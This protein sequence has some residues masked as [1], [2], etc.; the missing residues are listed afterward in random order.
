MP[1][2]TTYRRWGLSLLCATAVCTTAAMAQ[3]GVSPMPETDAPS[4]PAQPE[5][6]APETAPAPDD[7]PETA[8]A[9]DDAP[10]AESDVHEQDRA[11]QGEAVKVGAFGDI[12]LAADELDITTV[13]RLL[14]MKA[15]RNIITSRNVTGTVSANI[16]NVDFYEALE[17]ILTTN[18]FGYVEK[19]NFIYVYTQEELAQLEQAQRQRKTEIIRLNYINAADASTFVKSLL[20]DGGSIA[21]SGDAGE[22]SLGGGGASSGGS[23]GSAFSGNGGNDYAD[24]DT[25]VIRDYEEKIE[26]IR[27]L[28]DELDTRP[29]QVLIESTILQARLSEANAFGVDFALFADLDVT[30][31]TNPL[32]AVNDLIEGETGGETGGAVTASPGNVASGES[33]MKLGFLGNDAAVF[34]R[35]LDAVTDTTVL[36]TPKIAVLNRQAADLHVG[37]SLGYLST[38]ATE[39]STTQTVEFLDVGTQ[40]TVRPFISDDG[41]VR[42]EL[43][44]HVSDGDTELVGGFVIPNE[45]TQ[46]L[47]TNVIV[48]NGQTVVLGGLFKEDTSIGRRQV[49]GLGSIPIVGNAFKGQDDD[50]RRS[51]VIF[52]IKPTILKDKALGEA[53]QRAADNVE[54]ARVGAREGLLPWSQTKLTSSYVKQA[55]DQIREG[56]EEKALWYTNLA[57]YLDPTMVDALRLKEHLSG[58]DTYVQ[59][60]SIL[61]DAIDTLIESEMDEVL[62]LED[63]EVAPEEGQEPAEPG[64]Q[65]E[66]AEETPAA[67][68]ADQPVDETS[69]EE[70]E[71]ASPDV[72]ANDIADDVTESVEA[73]LI[74][75]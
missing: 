12:Q 23:G 50:V 33:T 41:F 30:D 36:A 66:P 55:H 67:R 25:L 1:K 34:I 74:G 45:T 26:E 49:P 65:A 73:E 69:A 2:H 24:A 14:S 64:T 29:R 47:T 22:I 70:E 8:P 62:P 71:V 9:P 4:A 44:P 56:D 52:L 38:T 61:D 18:G 16:Q 48:R 27:A 20:S 40:L 63:G 54:L 75:G 60:R 5:Q 39:T 46:K 7:A 19:G 21:I 43:Q 51:E 35:A 59:D 72:T 6:P 3:E 58:E 68:G 32:G 11:R 15:E 28:I 37:A 53:G 57:L 10:E 42:M 13:L 17:A 31:F